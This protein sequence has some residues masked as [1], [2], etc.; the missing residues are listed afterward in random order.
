VG[1]FVA[2]A[3]LVV[4]AVCQWFLAKPA[5]GDI[6]RAVFRP[7]LG[8]RASANRGWSRTDARGVYAASTVER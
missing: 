8:R 6:N 2:A 1:F 3:V 5:V 4:F 7:F